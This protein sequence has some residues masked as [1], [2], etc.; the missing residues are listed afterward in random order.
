MRS[1]FIEFCHQVTNNWD[2]SETWF[3]TSVTNLAEYEECEGSQHRMWNGTGY[4]KLFEILMVSISIIMRR[5]YFSYDFTSVP[6]FS[7]KRLLRCFV[8]EKSEI[9]Q[10]HFQ[11]ECDIVEHRGDANFF[12]RVEHQRA[13]RMCRWPNDSGG[14]CHRY[15]I[16]RSFARST[17]D[18][19]RPYAP[20][21][22]VENSLD[23]C[24]YTH[25]MTPLST[26]KTEVKLIEKT[27]HEDVY[28]LH[29]I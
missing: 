4:R 3:D 27:F 13:G 15:F 22:R 11:V 29:R 26:L 21:T 1:E 18:T 12:K 10:R 20:N 7:M 5:V 14:S 23:K 2:A 24:Q 25:S 28:L 17:S 9:V 16:R 8:G 19:V 6:T